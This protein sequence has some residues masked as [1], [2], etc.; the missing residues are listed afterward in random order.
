MSRSAFVS[1]LLTQSNVIAAVE[2]GSKRIDDVAAELEA[3]AAPYFG[4]DEPPLAFE[5]SINYL[6]PATA[7]N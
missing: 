5:I 6:R 7:G 3:G 4:N 1:F 2:N